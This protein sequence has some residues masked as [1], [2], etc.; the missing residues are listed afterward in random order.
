MPTIE[1]QNKVEELTQLFND[2]SILITTDY[3]GLGVSQINELRRALQEQGVNFRV[4]KNSL[5]YLAA[6]AA[7]KPALKDV[8]EGQTGITFTTDEPTIPAKALSDFIKKT[9]YSLKILGAELDGKALGA[10]EVQRLAALPSKDELVSMLLSR[11]QS[12]ISGLVNVLN[13][14]LTGLTVVLQRHADNLAQ[15]EDPE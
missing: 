10:E 2:S 6:D 14:P 3:S 13:G 9:R 11:M 15:E 7:G 5:A 4:I 12:P 1:K 8:I